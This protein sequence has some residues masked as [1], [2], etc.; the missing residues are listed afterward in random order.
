MVALALTANEIRETYRIKYGFTKTI[1]KHRII[2]PDLLFITT[3][4]AFGKSSIYNRLKYKGEIVAKSLGYTKGSGTFHIPETI[5]QK[6]LAFL[7]SKGI[8]TS[9][10]YG[11]GPS[12]KLKLISL[13]FRFLQLH[14]YEYHNLQR[15]F[16]IF[17]LVK[18]LMEVIKLREEPIYFDRPFDDLVNFWKERWA[19]PRAKRKPEWN[20]FEFI[21]FLTNVEKTLKDL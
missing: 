8:D 21:D 18:N 12:R 10:G 5:Y 3:T 11:H 16:Y 13:A 7:K 6:I 19:L 17:P 2:E 4:S 1:I 9:R 14:K 20:E 15:E